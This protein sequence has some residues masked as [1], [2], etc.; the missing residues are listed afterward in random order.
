MLGWNAETS[1]VAGWILQESSYV[2]SKFQIR[3]DVGI[4]IRGHEMTLTQKYE[5]EIGLEVF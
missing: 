3:E 5:M 4:K 1:N 2:I